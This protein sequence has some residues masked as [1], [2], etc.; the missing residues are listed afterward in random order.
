M[1]G[2]A[3]TLVDTSYIMSSSE[4]AMSTTGW[5]TAPVSPS[6]TGVG[7]AGPTNGALGSPDMLMTTAA[8]F[9]VEGPD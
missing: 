1:N 2:Y 9:A 6:L 4:V 5:L 7:T 8:G 3:C